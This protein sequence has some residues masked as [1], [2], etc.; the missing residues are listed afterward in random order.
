MRDIVCNE[1]MNHLQ[2]AGFSGIFDTA[3]PSPQTQMHGPPAHG[4]RPDSFSP[5]PAVN[6]CPCHRAVAEATALM[7]SLS[8]A[9][10]A[11]LDSLLDTV[12]QSPIDDWRGN[13]ADLFRATLNRISLQAHA[14]RNEIAQTR[15]LT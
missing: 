1:G 6:Q 7:D 3:M 8:R 11:T 4:R 2:P 9:T 15:S 5:S 10:F 12:Q 13:A 14:L